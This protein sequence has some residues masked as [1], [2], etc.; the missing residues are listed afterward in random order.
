MTTNEGMREAIERMRG[1]QAYDQVK[2]ALVDE[3]LRWK[4][5]GQLGWI[6]RR[7]REKEDAQLTFPFRSTT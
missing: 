7:E 5:E 4:E 3:L 6:R 1:N 2:F